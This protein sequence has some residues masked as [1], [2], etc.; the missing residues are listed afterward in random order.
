VR[1][2]GQVTL[3][4]GAVR[5]KSARCDWRV[6]GG[7]MKRV[8]Q[9]AAAIIGVI[10]FHNLAAG[11]VGDVDKM[12]SEARTALGGEKRLAALKTFT[13]TGQSTRVAGDRSFPAADVE[14]TFE[15]PDRFV[16]TEPMGPGG[17][18]IRTSGFNGDA[19]IEAMDTPPGMAGRVVFR[20]GPGG[21]PGVEP[22]PEQRE[23]QNRRLLLNAR[24]EFARLALGMLL[25]SP[26]YPLEFSYVGQA[27]SP[28]GTADVIEVKGEGEFA[29]RLF[30]DS[31]TRFPLMLSWMAREPITMTSVMG[32]GAGA[33]RAAAR[34]APCA[35]ARPPAR[36]RRCRPRRKSARSCMK[37]IE[38]KANKP[39][40]T[41]AS[42]STASS[43]ATTGR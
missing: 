42:S 3:R 29:A 20:I 15:L 39:K 4:E 40:P 5:K 31:A 21:T 11:Q 14:I 9:A 37:E 8:L 34:V 32:P 7:N 16:R 26:V 22:T 23:E 1:K 13:A 6:A 35:P 38:E 28:D 19:L 43:T 27:E 30:I 12:L 2:A 18:I 36:R 24:Q 17:G 33:A 10:A 25:S 41:S